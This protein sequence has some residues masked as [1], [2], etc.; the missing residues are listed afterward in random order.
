MGKVGSTS[1]A[2]ALGTI[3]TPV[4]H[5]HHLT[6][7]ILDKVASDLKQNDLPDGHIGESYR[8]LKEIVEPG[9]PASLVSLVRDPIARNISA[10]F[11]N[12]KL[13]GGSISDIDQLIAK[14]I[15]TYPHNVPLDYFDLQIKSIF[16]VDVFDKP[17]DHAKHR[18]IVEHDKY[19]MLVLRVEDSDEQKQ[20]ALREFFG[21]DSLVVSRANIAANKPYSKT[22]SKFIDRIELPQSYINKMLESKFARHFYTDDELAGFA[23]KWSRPASRSAA[24]PSSIPDKELPTI[25]IVSPSYNQADF[26]KRMLESVEMQSYSPAEHVILDGVSS[27]GTGKILEQ[28]AQKHDWVDLTIAKDNG[29]VD[30]INQG[31]SRSTADIVTWLNTDDIYRDPDVL[32]M[33]AETFAANPDVDIVYARGRFVDPDGELLR[34]VFINS[35]PDNL[36]QEFTHSVG[37]LQPALFFRR[38]V[39]ERFGPLDEE[40]SCAFDYEYWIRLARGGAKFHFVDKV[41]VDATLHENSKT[42]G[43]RATQYAHTLESVHRHYGFVPR[44]WLRRVAEH[45]VCGIDGIVQNKKD[46]PADQAD[47]IDAAVDVLHSK[48]NGSI[49]AYRRLLSRPTTGGGSVPIAETIADLRRRS[50]MNTD[51]TIVTSFNSAYYQQGL[52]LIA[53]LHRLAQ[54]AFSQIIVYDVD[55]SAKE[56]EALC[57]LDRVAVRDYPAETKTFF[58]GYMAP[59][60]YAY[61][62][63]AIK[64]AGDLVR[65][66]DRVLWIDAGVVIVHSI[67]E[68]FDRIA[69]DGAF[70]VDH[71][72]KPTWPIRNSGFTHP[73][74]AIK[75]KATGNELLAPHLC[76]CLLGYTRGGKAQQLIEDAYVYSQDPEIVAWTKHP[77]QEAVLSVGDMPAPRRKAY[78]EIV[79]K[80][81][82]G[83]KVKA[84]DVLR[85]TSYFGH[86]QDQSIYSILCARY[87]FRQSS[88]T[89]FCWSDSESSTASLENWKSGG[90][91]DLERSPSLPDSMPIP[92]I[93]YHHRGLY[94][95]LDGLQIADKAD[96]LVLLGN[97][98]SLKEFDFD[99]LKGADTLG[100]NA[101]YRYWD[102]VNWYPTYY[103]CMDKVVIM[104]HEEEILRLINERKQNGIRKF[105]LRKI[106]ADA[107]P[108]IRDNPAVVILEDVRKSYSAFA[109]KDITTGNFSALFGATLGYKKIMLL[110]IDC[111]YVEQISEAAPAG[112]TRL[113]IKSTPSA[114]P[115]YF[116]DDYQQSGDLYNIPNVS[117]GFH[118]GSWAESQQ[119]LT[120][121]GVEVRNCNMQSELKIFPFADIEDEIQAASKP[122]PTPKPTTIGAEYSRDAKAGIDELMLVRDAIGTSGDDDQMI[123]VGAHHG[124]STAI[125]L[126]QNWNVLAFEPDPVNRER[127]TKRHGKNPKFKLDPRAAGNKEQKAVP[128]YTSDQSSGVSSLAAFTAVHKETD[129][130]DVTTLSIALK[131]HGIESVRLLKIDAEGFDKHVL[132]GFPWDRMKPSV[133]MCEFEDRK[134]LD[135]GYSTADMAQYLVD[136]GY[137]VLV[138][139]W[140][141]IV[142]YGV[143]HD[144][145]RLFRFGVNEVAP[146]SWGN[147]IAFR[148]ETDAEAFE[149]IVRMAVR[150]GSLTNKDLVQDAPPMVSTVQ[151]KPAS[152]GPRQNA[153]H[154]PKRN[155]AMKPR[156][157]LPPAR[158]VKGKLPWEPRILTD[159]ST[160]ARVKLAVG[161]L[162]RVYAGRAGVMA[163]AMILCW[164]IGVIALAFGVPAWFGM[165]MG[166]IS[167][168]PLFALIGFVAITARR[169]AYENDEAM[170]RSVE[171]AIRQ[172]A[173][174]IQRKRNNQ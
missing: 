170:R 41:I 135:L 13:M 16:G 49:D 114:N 118:A 151:P 103:A 57:E 60:N 45:E 147:L 5:V 48:W 78:R 172:A 50:P 87:N 159:G 144:W 157:A 70:F 6:Q 26:V 18:Q 84:D 27:D 1:V 71:D 96:S 81:T 36:E 121:L 74:A 115:N 59:K 92:A 68:I 150:E 97:G 120:D 110:G 109:V 90:E 156:P 91:A 46:V 167:L 152:H 146:Q 8:V 161:K 31:F 107:H 111:N 20:A 82:K 14:F 101:A 130:V 66:G 15:D 141:P 76:S 140:H 139:E 122:A 171:A 126:R 148:Y 145:R 77:G 62:C 104:S 63:A 79:D 160:E 72:D 166:T 168:V 155:I 132:E 39:F 158:F 65:D 131:E 64:A 28:F 100:M 169:Q 23:D 164:L 10:F 127:S 112:A 153:A 37:I 47:K 51:K 25:G 54:D 173:N 53:S 163:A 123:D 124:G 35:S 134:T 9:L 128:F 142:R 137:R 69:I 30:A 149:D 61:K 73:E 29:Q 174:H 2:R 89:R 86:R 117:P 93:T 12:K 162:G 85:L 58:D 119:V 24:V 75:M 56:R 80:F 105:F 125:F 52:N 99:K 44:R 19:S 154:Q 7:D 22:Y 3:D 11:Q 94:D 17:F 33:I 32:R 34:K 133:I 55:F 98:P 4:F 38:E 42:Q 165:L 106:L 143:Q 43:Q 116:F 95:N 136:H 138:S 83:G 67:E 102:R 21:D 40:L 88:A 113:E 108:E 129:T